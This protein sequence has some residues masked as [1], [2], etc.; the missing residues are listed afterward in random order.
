MAN[1]RQRR[2]QKRAQQRTVREALWF[3]A[4]HPLLASGAGAMVAIGI[5]SELAGA[6]MLA[7][8]CY[9]AALALLIVVF[10]RADLFRLDPRKAWGIL[11]VSAICLFVLWLAIRPDPPLSMSE[12]AKEIAKELPAATP[13][14][15]QRRPEPTP[16]PNVWEQQYGARESLFGMPD[17]TLQYYPPYFVV[18]IRIRCRME[19]RSKLGTALIVYIPT[20]PA[21]IGSK[22]VVASARFVM[23]NY[24]EIVSSIVNDAK[25]DK[26]RDIALRGQ[27]VKPDRVVFY[28]AQPIMTEDVST[29]ANLKRPRSLSIERYGP[30]W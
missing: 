19:Y 25:A 2:K 10:V 8:L 13:Q 17:K 20:E 23:D 28:H 15:T 24:N 14:V 5:G 4:E 27:I 21:G 29:I 3:I 12:L 18:P 22:E 11:V 6:S 9:I 16:T 30:K 26:T 1:S 7:A